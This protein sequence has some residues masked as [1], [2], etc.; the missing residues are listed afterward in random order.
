MNCEL[1]LI[2]DA[3]GG[4]TEEMPKKNPGE[5]EGAAGAE[6]GCGVSQGKMGI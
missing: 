2:T 4:D 1:L 5:R 3:V 6:G